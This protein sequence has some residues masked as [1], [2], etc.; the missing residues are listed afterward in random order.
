MLIPNEA[1]AFLCV[2]QPINVDELLISCRF[3]ED[4]QNAV[5]EDADFKYT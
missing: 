4:P 3:F 5:S 2:V 1:L